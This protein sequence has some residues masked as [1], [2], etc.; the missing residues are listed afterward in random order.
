M[1][2][3]DHAGPRTTQW[4][5]PRASAVAMVVV[6]FG[7]AVVY[8]VLMGTSRPGWVWDDPARNAAMEHMLY[9]VYVTLGVFL[10]VLAREPERAVPLIDWVIL[11]SPSNAPIGVGA[12]L[13]GALLDGALVVRRIGV[14]RPQVRL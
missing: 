4:G 11:N 2:G 12:L 9:A 13:D 7:Y 6:G 3:T 10:I 5:R 8:P 14:V 1:T